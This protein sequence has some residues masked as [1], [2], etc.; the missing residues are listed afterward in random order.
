MYVKPQLYIID[1]EEKAEGVYVPLIIIL[2]KYLLKRD[3]YKRIIDYMKSLE[4][5]NLIS[6]IVQGELWNKKYKN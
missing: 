6:N 5:Q 4:H 3:M 2:L 1:S